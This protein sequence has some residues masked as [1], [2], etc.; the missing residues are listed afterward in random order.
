[1]YKFLQF[2]F[3]VSKFVAQSMTTIPP[4]GHGNN[5]GTGYLSNRVF[6]FN[7]ILT[8]PYTR[9]PLSIFLGYP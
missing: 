8:P 4:L 5:S 2:K 1:M 3:V 7:T 6:V 9:V